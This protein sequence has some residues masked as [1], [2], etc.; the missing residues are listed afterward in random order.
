M[1]LLLRT[2]LWLGGVVAEK[3]GEL[4]IEA[5]MQIIRKCALPRPL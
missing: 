1:A 5:L 3:R 2:R 4:L